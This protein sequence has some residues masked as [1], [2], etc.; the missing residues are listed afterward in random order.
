MPANRQFKALRK[1]L[2]SKKTIIA[3]IILIF[4]AIITGYVFPQRFS[5]SPADL[6]KWKETHPFWAP[7]V[8]RIGLDHVYTT[9]WFAILLLVFLLSLITSLIEQ[10]KTS[11]RKTYGKSIPLFFPESFIT[12]GKGGSFESA[13]SE[14]VLTKAIKKEGYFQFAEGY[15][16]TRFTKYPWGHWGNVLL[17]FGIVIAIASSL[18]IVLTQ[19]RGVVSLV[20]GES[21]APG[22]DWTLETHGILAK[23]LVLPATLR[24]D[25]VI[26]EFWETD[27]LKQLTTEFSFID[28]HS[29]AGSFKI[30]INKVVNYKG[31]RL[32]QKDFGPALYV[33][34]IDKDGTVTR[35]ILLIPVPSRRDQASYRDFT[36]TSVPFKI[37]TK[38]FA[39]ARKKSMDSLDPLL[40]LRFLKSGRVVGETQLRVGESGKI[41]HYTANLVSASKWVSLIFVAVS[42]MSGIY[43]S[44]F[45]IVL[46]GVLHYFTPPRDFIIIKSEGRILVSWRGTRFTRFYVDEYERLESAFKKT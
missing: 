22:S 3:L 29:D 1:F 4:T 11:I 21:F 6:W 26:P 35:S 19:Q 37:E 28:S 25:K 14:E 42:G 18:L 7:W 5:T 13:R 41:G 12:E 10:T 23:E 17:H 40:V 9:P 34:F 32:Y 45:V 24:I 46:G 39:D 36:V 8:R 30:S 44:F 16:W 2:L 15:N 31:I 20:E 43:L 33:T 27:D 38:Y